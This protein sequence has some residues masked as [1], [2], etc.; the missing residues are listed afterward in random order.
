MHYIYLLCLRVN[1][2]LQLELLNYQAFSIHSVFVQVPFIFIKLI[3]WCWFPGGDDIRLFV[4]WNSPIFWF[5]L[6]NL[7]MTRTVF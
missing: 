5:R 7:C 2:I 4:Q 1:Y 6:K 3:F